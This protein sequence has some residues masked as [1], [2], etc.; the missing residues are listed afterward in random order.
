MNFLNF[1]FPKQ[2]DSNELTHKEAQ[3]IR[4]ALIAMDY[5]LEA[6]V[7]ALK[8]YIQQLWLMCD[9]ENKETTPYFKKLNKAKDNLR[10]LKAKRKQIALLLKDLK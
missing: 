7:E 4:Q 5:E 6:E 8:P 2:E 3:L 10:K 9:P 1:F